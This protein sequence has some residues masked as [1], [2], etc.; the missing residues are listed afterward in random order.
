MVLIIGS[1]SF[2]FIMLGSADYIGDQLQ[3]RS[4]SSRFKRYTTTVCVCITHEKVLL[5]LTD[6]RNLMRQITGREEEWESG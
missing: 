2:A 6:L 3:L 4:T 5:T 1:W